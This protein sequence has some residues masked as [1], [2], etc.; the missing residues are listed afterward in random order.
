MPGMATFKKKNIPQL[1]VKKKKMSIH[2]DLA[3]FFSQLTLVY[4]LNHIQNLG[5]RLFNFFQKKYFIFGI[6]C[7][8]FGFFFLNKLI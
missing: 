5:W 3:N 8:I 7:E 6:S 1:K 2:F 4:N